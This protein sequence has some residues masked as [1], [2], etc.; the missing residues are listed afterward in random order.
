MLSFSVQEYPQAV[1]EEADASGSQPLQAVRPWEV[2][3]D[4]MQG[5]EEVQLSVSYLLKS[6]EYN[7][8]HIL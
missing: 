3:S 6:H 5:H 4:H 1:S 7:N 2:P 8:S